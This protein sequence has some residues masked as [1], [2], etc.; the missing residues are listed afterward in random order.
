MP[1]AFFLVVNAHDEIDYIIRTMR[2]TEELIESKFFKDKKIARLV[3]IA[4]SC[5]KKNLVD[6]FDKYS[7]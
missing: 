5:K 3:F 6:D 1:D 4:R 7:L 2:S